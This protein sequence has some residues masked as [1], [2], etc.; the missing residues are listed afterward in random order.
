MPFFSSKY[1]ILNTILFLIIQREIWTI[2]AQL[3]AIYILQ[4]AEY[5]KIHYLLYINKF[6]SL[7]VTNACD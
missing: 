2:A 7:D 6:I 1:G 4:R 5:S 3:S